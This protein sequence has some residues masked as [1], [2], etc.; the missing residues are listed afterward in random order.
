MGPAVV[1]VL[2]EGMEHAA[3]ASPAGRVEGSQALMQRPATQQPWLHDVRQPISVYRPRAALASTAQHRPGSASSSAGSCC[4][5]TRTWWRFQ[6]IR[7]D[8][9]SV[10]MPCCFWVF[11]VGKWKRR[12]ISKLALF[13]PTQNNTTVQ[14]ASQSRLF[15]GLDSR[16]PISFDSAVESLSLGTI[17]KHADVPKA[18]RG[19][20]KAPDFLGR[21]LKAPVVKARKPKGIL[22]LLYL[23]SC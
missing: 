18:R 1:I 9:A 23:Q 3:E 22:E 21:S 20:G 13:S 5:W 8:L 2:V 15:L 19:E 16:L 4:R 6:R 7:R 12:S 10:A 11:Q 14:C 17:S